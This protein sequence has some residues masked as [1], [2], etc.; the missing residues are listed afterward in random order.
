MKEDWAKSLKQKMAGFQEPVD[1]ALWAGIA[2]VSVTKGIR[3]W[4]WV[5]AALASAAV[6]TIVLLLPEPVVE[7]GV[8]H[9][10]EI[11]SAVEEEPITETVVP[12]RP[13]RLAQNKSVPPRIE[14]E[15]FSPQENVD[16]KKQ[17]ED[18][19][20]ITPGIMTQEAYP[21]KDEWA[22]M[23]EEEEESVPP[24]KRIKIATSFY[25]QASPL[26][27]RH[28]AGATPAQENPPEP[29]TGET[30]DPGGP[31]LGGDGDPG[32]TDHHETKASGPSLKKAR[33]PSS[34]A[35]SDWTHAF[36]VQIGARVSFSWSERWSIDTG[37][38][39]MHFNSWNADTQQ[40]MEFL[41]IPLYVN[42]LIGSARNF[43]FF[44]AAGGQ[45]FKCFAGNAPDK[46]WLFSCGLGVG[47]EY[48]FSP[49]V[50]LYAEPGAD[51]YFHTGESHHYYTDNPF[52]FSLS[53]GIR[54]H[55]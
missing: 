46:P 36:P 43:S 11:L 25:A 53:L 51:W 8:V 29:P 17:E 27:N 40:R 49:L 12:D 26:G 37:L 55:F 42:Y 54:F 16:E 9:S 34:S 38:T 15:A 21:A 23:I 35:S 3:Q 4:P 45:A 32:E 30:T 39:F 33:T 5:T 20:L 1:D 14:T 28:S 44:A 47:A 48:M 7:P 19:R 31:T 18:G 50:S 22:K 13:I 41:G 52:A 6:I 10:G 24:R 2:R